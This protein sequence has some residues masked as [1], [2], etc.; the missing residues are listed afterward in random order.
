VAQGPDG[1]GERLLRTL[2]SVWD[3]PETQVHM[4]AVARSMLV[5]DGGRLLKDGFLPVVVVPVLA[6]LVRDRPEDR[7]PLVASQIIGLIVTR[8]VVAVPAMAQLPAEDLV[9]RMGPV[10][11]HYL[12]GDLP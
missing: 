3:D 6:A 11:Q 12:T 9:T 2:F 4:L 1:A 8:Y 10:L 7:V 5:E